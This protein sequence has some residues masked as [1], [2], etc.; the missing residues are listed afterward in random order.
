MGRAPQQQARNQIAPPSHQVAPAVM[1]SLR[2]EV[3]PMK[4]EFSKML[5]PHIPVERFVRV[6]MN[7]IQATPRLAMCDRQSFWNACMMAAEDALL[8]DKREGA[9]VPFKKGKDDEGGSPGGPGDYVATWIPMVLGV[10]KLIRQSGEISDLNVQLVYVDEMRA[11]AFVHR[12]GDDPALKHERL[13]FDGDPAARPVY[14]GYSLA[15]NK[16][17]VL[18]V[19]EVMFENEIMAVARRSKSFKAGPWSDPLFALE[20][21][22]KTVTKRHFKQLPTSRDLDR[23]LGRDDA[24]YDFGRGREE[25]ARSNERPVTIGGTRQALDHFASAGGSAPVDDQ[26]EPGKDARVETDGEP[27]AENDD[28]AG[29][30]Q[31]SAERS[32]AP[33]PPSGSADSRQDDQ[34]K[35]E[36]PDAYTPWLA[37]WLATCKTANAVRTRWKAETDLRLSFR[38]PEPTKDHVTRWREMWEA[39]VKEVETK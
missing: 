32:S 31:R 22:K 24:L 15:W 9:I 6:V 29:K 33:E 26:R 37:A 1:R 17:R 39:R 18:Y 34:P 27:P 23:V 28:T 38:E 20:M 36:N 30:D 2:E 3:E 7:A 14:A 5:P 4:R 35:P 21:R 11:G 8:P 25:V 19:P 16:D 13:P 12:L 10:R